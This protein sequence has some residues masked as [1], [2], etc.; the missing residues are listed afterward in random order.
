MS[1]VRQIAKSHPVDIVFTGKQT[2][3]GDTAQVGPGIAIRLGWELLTYVSKIRSIDTETKRIVIERRA[4]GGVQV[5]ESRLP[6]VMT[7]LE[8][9][10]EMRFADMAGMFRAAR[11][12]VPHWG[13]AGAGIEDTRQAGM[14]GSPTAVAQV[15]APKPKEV[16][17]LVI[18]GDT[19]Q[20]KAEALLDRMFADL[21]KLEKSLL[22]HLDALGA[23]Q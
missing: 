17:A 12:D 18:A 21:P 5:L 13:V 8:G 19:P 9:I 14:K 11:Y 6:C 16:K 22:D 20:A 10:N 7:L 1:A 3:D 23:R 4:E 15:F 2:I